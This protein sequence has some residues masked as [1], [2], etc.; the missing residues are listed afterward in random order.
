MIIDS[1]KN[2]K[3]DINPFKTFSR[4]RVSILKLKFF[5]LFAAQFCQF[6][7]TGDEG[8]LGT[9]IY[10]NSLYCSWAIETSPGTNAVVQVYYFIKRLWALILTTSYLIIL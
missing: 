5:T 9:L 1:P 4:L 2:G 7:H 6:Y 10:R 3:V 8:S